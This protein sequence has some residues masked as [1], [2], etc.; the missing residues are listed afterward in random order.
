MSKR[1][2]YIE[3][4][5][6][7]QNLSTIFILPMLEY[8]PEFFPKEFIDT[9][10]VDSE[11]DKKIICIFEDSSSEDLKGALWQMQNH[12]DFHSIDYADNNKEI[13][14]VFNIPKTR[15]V[16]FNLFLVGR[17]TKFSND[18]KEILLDYH[19]RK[20]GAGKSIMMIDALFPDHL[21]K[22]WRADKMSVPGSTPVSINDL[23]GGEVVSI[24][25]LD[26]EKYINID[27]LV[28]GEEEAK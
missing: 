4:N 18:Y 2:K 8:S 24:P 13:V 12:D 5:G 11:D 7:R 9:Y 14:V 6:L 27:E 16:D 17:Y 28:K 21:A 22:K 1:R 25:D 23:P 20:S 10:I 26:K 3:E 19:G 15:E